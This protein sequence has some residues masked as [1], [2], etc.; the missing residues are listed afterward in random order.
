MM[1]KPVCY[2]LTGPTASGKTAL[3]VRLA[4]R[5]DC[6][7]IAMDSMQLYRGM[8]IGTAKPT[9][10]EMQGIPHHMIDVADPGESFSVARYQEM[11]EAAAR[12]ILQ[13]GKRV[14]YV[15]GTG[16][17]LRALRHPMAMGVVSGDEAL[18]EELQRQADTPGGKEALHR[19][20][21]QVDPDTAAR[22]P[23][24]DVRRVMRALEVFRLTGIPFSKQPAQEKEPPFDY[25]VISLDMDRAL[26]YARIEKRVD[27]MLAQGLVE[28]VRRLLEQG[29]PPDCQAMKAIGY[30]EM[31]PVLRGECTLE[32]AVTELKKNT[33]HYAKRQLTWMRREEDVLWL[34]A[35][36]PDTEERAFRWLREEEEA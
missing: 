13:R 18:R 27:E 33:R 6:E 35:M 23:V 5:L 32:A 1:K 19:Q 12:D 2:I 31:L 9:P 22:L 14:L 7:I 25:R 4:K 34:D 28:E 8:D 29:V 16:F 36:S 11:A 15:G 20:L 10:E 3:S 21:E 30:K 26:L 24:G 17:Y